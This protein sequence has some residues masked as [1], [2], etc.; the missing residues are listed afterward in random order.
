ME[1]RDELEN[2]G[3]PGGGRWGPVGHPARDVSGPGW[4]RPRAGQQLP[5]RLRRDQQRALQHHLGGGDFDHP[6][7]LV[8]WQS[9]SAGMIVQRYLM[10]STLHGAFIYLCG[11]QTAAGATSSTEQII[12]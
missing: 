7:A 11:G 1:D 4:V 12:W 9:T 3:R 8:N 5:V 2:R 10:G 6:P